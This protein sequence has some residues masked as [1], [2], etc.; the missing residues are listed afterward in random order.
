MA[1]I[2]PGKASCR[3]C[4]RV[5]TAGSIPWLRLAI[6]F[7][8]IVVGVLTALLLESWVEY[9][10]DR[11]LEAQYLE[12]IQLDLRQNQET[13]A[14]AV[15]I[16]RHHLELLKKAES[17]MYQSGGAPSTDS[18]RAWL[19]QRRV[20]LWYY[21]DPRLVDGTMTALVETGHLALLR[22][23]AL[24]SAIL[25][26]LGQVRADSEEFRRWIQIGLAAES[27]YTAR[28]EVGLSLDVPPEDREAMR[29]IRAFADPEGRVA[30]EDLRDAFD[31]RAWY[32][33]QM[34]A[35]TASL[36]GMLGAVQP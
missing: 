28:G 15:D 33:E 9:E 34:Q 20:G 36:I 16:E 19:G 21:S 13:L 29:L 8:V 12:Q 4:A 31:S 27:V 23:P 26:Y 5:R 14:G 2:S 10:G 6:E 3:R 18:I 11:D 7:G 30:I 17:A 32:L 35:A 25:G 1:P 22:D 24:R